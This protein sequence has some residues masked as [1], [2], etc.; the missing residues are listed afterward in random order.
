MLVERSADYGRTWKVF[1]Y[2]A[3]DCATSFPNITSG[4][5]QGVGDLV[6]DSKYSDIEPSTGGEVAFPLLDFFDINLYNHRP[7]PQKIKP[8]WLMWLI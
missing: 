6:C 3:K 4:Q 1:K 2:F 5:A 8:F 7:P